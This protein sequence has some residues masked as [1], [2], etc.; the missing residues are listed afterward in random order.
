MSAEGGTFTLNTQPAQRIDEMLEEARERHERRPS[1]PFAAWHVYSICRQRRREVPEWVLEHFDRV[2]VIITGALP[3]ATLKPEHLYKI[4]A[5][6]LNFKLPGRSGRGDL[7]SRVRNLKE[8]DRIASDV[9]A[10]RS[11]GDGYKQA[12]GKVAAARGLDE[13]DVERAWSGSKS[14]RA[15]KA[16]RPAD[17]K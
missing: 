10:V 11:A 2:A 17:K 4:L 3:H 14:Q 15:W 9:S 1:D 6:A 8:R 5:E 13:R 16:A 7:L 12:V